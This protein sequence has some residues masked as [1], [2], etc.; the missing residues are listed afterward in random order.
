[1]VSTTTKNRSLCIQAQSVCLL[2]AP[3]PGRNVPF[4]WLAHQFGMSSLCRSAHSLELFLRHSSLNLW[5]VGGALVESMP[6]RPEGHGF[7]S[8]SSRHVGTLG[9]SFTHSCLRCFGVNFR[10]SIRAV[11]GAP[12]SSSGLESAL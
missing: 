4:Q 7:D 12:L 6:F 10:H 3:P 9:K 8:R 1:M 2:H 5:N 11:S